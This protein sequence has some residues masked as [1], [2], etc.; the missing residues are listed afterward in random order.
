[1]LNILG[2]DFYIRCLPP[3]DIGGKKKPVNF[4]PGQISLPL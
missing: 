4:P 1:M 3:R 2:V